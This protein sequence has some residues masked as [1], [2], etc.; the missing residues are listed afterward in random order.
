MNKHLLTCILLLS[1]VL[2]FFVKASSNNLLPLMPYPKSVLTSANEVVLKSHFNLQIEGMSEQRA[3]ALHQRFSKQLSSLGWPSSDNTDN[4]TLIKINVNQGNSTRYQLPKL[5]QDES[6]QLKVEQQGITIYAQTDFG[7]LQ[8]IASL[9]QLLYSFYISKRLPELN[10]NDF[11]R[12]PWRGFMLDSVRHF[13]SINTVKRQLDGMA[14]AKLNVFHWH[15]TD[16]QGWRIEL[17]SYPKLHQKASDGQ[18]Y[19][20]AEIKDVVS[21]ASKLGIRVVPEFDV[22]GHASAIA[23]AYPELMSKNTNYEMEDGWGVFE[24]L[25]D[26]S[27]PDVYIFV[28]EVVK[29]LTSLFPD[30]YLHIG[31]DEV[32]PKHWQESEK[33]QAYMQEH[34]LKDE[35]DLH[36]YFN[37]KVQNILNKYDRKMM[38]WD[39]IF[40]P[41]LPKDIMVQSWRGM[42]SLN[43][44]ASAGYQGLLSTGFYIDQPQS[45][46]YHYRNELI[47]NLADAPVALTSADTVT[48]YSVKIPR[49]KGSAVTGQLVMVKRND[50]VLHAYVKL[51]NNKFKKATLDKRMALNKEDIN[52]SIDS[53]MG[54]TRFELNTNKNKIVE[55][56]VLIGNTFYPLTINVLPEFDF[57]QV[58][59]LRNIAPTE[60]KNILGGEATLWAELLTEQNT[61]LR[62]WPRL[63]VIAERFWS[64]KAMTNEAE[65]FRRLVIM[66]KFADQLGL[67]HKAQLRDGL[68]SLA[69]AN[70]DIKPLLSLVEQL[71]PANYYT[72]H[73]IKYQQDLYHQRAKLNYF[74]DFLPAESL[75]ITQLDYLLTK[76]KQGDKASMQ[77]IINTLRA[78]HF[79]YKPVIKLI[80]GAPKLQ[81]VL[82]VARQARQINTIALTIAQACQANVKMS[83]AEARRIKTKLRGWHNQVSEIII[84]TNLFTERLLDTCMKQSR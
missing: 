59:L 33:I 45:S 81:Q 58:E 20:Q 72:R 34:Q 18:Y 5:H 46:S 32:N 15:L 57:Q 66:D 21:Y 3:L 8:G 12:F 76:F 19:T 35:H 84:A 23:V 48:A 74:V 73:H 29:E 49:L 9:H 31:G 14:A 71:E 28:E 11:P 6:Y 61:D 69:F 65:M 7:A 10:I 70:S 16:D 30:V 36:V 26:P 37:K 43:T 63:F 64:K 42:E 80:K 60:Q 56:R 67:K 27:N 55:G 41:D 52:L 62:A 51:N 68:Q 83:R 22:P 44:I 53:W 39:E 4:A 38:G 40:H 24:P 47:S 2:S 79:N 17:N 54:P 82:P 50:Y 75:T 25:L 13:L 77:A 1:G 78:W